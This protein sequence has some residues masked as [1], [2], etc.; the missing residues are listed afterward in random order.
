MGV[1]YTPGPLPGTEASQAVTRKQKA[2]MS[3]KTAAK[4]PRVAQTSKATPVKTIVKKSVV[5]V[6]PTKAKPRPKDTSKIELILVKP[7]GVSK[8]FCLSYALGPSQRWCDEGH[9]S[10]GTVVERAPCIISFDKLGNDSSSDVGDASP[11]KRMVDAP[12]PPLPLLHGEL[13]SHAFVDLLDILMF[14]FC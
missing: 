7:I 8:K 12:L 4:K 5:K 14:M 9:Q 11:P 13:P 6:I 3:K 10:V 1:P 2:N